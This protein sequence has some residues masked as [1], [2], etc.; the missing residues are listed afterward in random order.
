MIYTTISLPFLVDLGM[1]YQWVH[2]TIPKVG[3]SHSIS[4][5]YSSLWLFLCIL[6][7]PRHLG[8]DSRDGFCPEMWNILTLWP[9]IIVMLLFIKIKQPV[10]FLS[11]V[12]YYPLHIGD[13]RNRWNENPNKKQSWFWW[14]SGNPRHIIYTGLSNTVVVPNTCQINHNSMSLIRWSSILSGFLKIFKS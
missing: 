4:T 11:R 1:V 3:D 12:L 13:Y 14:W 5:C 2:H 6:R 7:V 9:L 8:R 10:F